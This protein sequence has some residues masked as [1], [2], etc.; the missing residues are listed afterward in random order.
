M[1]EIVASVKRVTDIV[2]EITAASQEQRSGIEEVSRAVTQ[3]DDATQQNAALVEQ[4]AAAAQ[5]LEEQAVSLT[6]VV[7]QFRLDGSMPAAQRALARAEPVMVA[8]SAAPVAP[9]APAPKAVDPAPARRPGQAQPRSRQAEAAT[10]QA[11]GAEQAGGQGGASCCSRIQQPGQ[12]TTAGRRWRRVQRRLGN[13][14]INQRG[15][16]PRMNLARAVRRGLASTAF[17]R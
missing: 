9:L 16:A 12:T 5:S 15:N 1:R 14:L 11:S 2:G 4:A 3:L 6:Q 13:L 7:A 8:A 10:A 17:R